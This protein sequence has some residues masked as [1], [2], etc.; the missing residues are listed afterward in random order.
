MRQRLAFVRALIHD[1]DILILFEVLRCFSY[2]CDKLPLTLDDA[3][4]DLL[5]K[6]KRKGI[7]LNEKTYTEIEK[8][9]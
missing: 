7:T 1:P 4:R 8:I 2:P 3:V 5:E 6:T 9:L